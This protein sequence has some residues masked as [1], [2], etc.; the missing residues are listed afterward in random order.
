[1]G[2]ELHKTWCKNFTKSRE[3]ERTKERKKERKK[4]QNVNS[5]QAVVEGETDDPFDLGMKEK[6]NR[7]QVQT[8]ICAPE[9][10]DVSVQLKI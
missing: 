6:K 1:M 4:R 3:T 10:A 9:G 8:D 7:K 5:K 2:T